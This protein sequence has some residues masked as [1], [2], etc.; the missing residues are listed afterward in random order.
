MV[1][2]LQS[3]STA[4]LAK[5]NNAGKSADADSDSQKGI[6]KNLNID[7]FGMSSD[8]RK[9]VTLANA[10]FELNYQVFKSM[11][12]S[13][14]FETTHETFSFKGSY[15]FLQQASGA[16]TVTSDTSAPGETAAEEL[17]EQ[18]QL[19]QLQEYFSPQNTARR[20]LD[21]ATSFFGV[22]ETGQGEGNTEQARR[23]FADFIGSA[24]NEGFR[25]ARGILGELPEDI[26]AGIDKTHSLVFAGLEDFVKNGIDPEKSRPGGVFEKIA[27]YREEASTR[28]AYVSSSSSAVSYNSNGEMQ[29]N[30][31]ETTKVSTR[32]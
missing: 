18:D 8:A 2:K 16:E 24:I 23:K 19:T 11:N 32:G 30:P 31:L 28:Q 1:D 25:Q 4:L 9:K 3:V 15:E 14:G 5:T 7:Q 17:S 13:Q 12:S 6:F 26:N 22:S 21:V 10:Q 29:T 20:I 27:A